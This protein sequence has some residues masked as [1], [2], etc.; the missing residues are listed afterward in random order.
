[1]KSNVFIEFLSSQ[2]KCYTAIRRQDNLATCIDAINTKGTH[3]SIHI[4]TITQIPIN[5]EFPHYNCQSAN[6]EPRFCHELV[7][8]SYF[9][10]SSIINLLPWLLNKTYITTSIG[11]KLLMICGK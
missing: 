9:I 2:R 10:A 7:C 11:N 8:L 4:L 5:S 3:S 6:H 1:M